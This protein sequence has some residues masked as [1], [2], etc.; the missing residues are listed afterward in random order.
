MCVYCTQVCVTYI[1]IRWKPRV[2]VAVQLSTGVVFVN[3]AVVIT[4]TVSSL[5]SL[6]NCIELTTWSPTYLLSHKE[7]L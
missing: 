4:L 7:T 3:A 6:I 1:A 5:M 2:A